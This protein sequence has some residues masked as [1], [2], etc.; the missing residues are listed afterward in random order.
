[1]VNWLRI[2]DQYIRHIWVDPEDDTIE[3]SVDPSFY[4]DN[5]TPTTEEGLD[6]LYSHTEISASVI[7]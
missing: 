7:P 1:M 3:I 4:A 6:M 5:G 2:E